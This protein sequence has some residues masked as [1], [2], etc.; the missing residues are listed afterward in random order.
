MLKTNDIKIIIKK[1]KPSYS[2]LRSHEKTVLLITETGRNDAVLQ[3]GP[4]HQASCSM[5][6]HVFLRCNTVVSGQE[7]YNKSLQGREPHALY[8]TNYFS[9]RFRIKAELQ[10]KGRFLS[11]SF[12]HREK[13]SERIYAQCTRHLASIWANRLMN[14]H[15]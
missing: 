3:R 2:D 4:V 11:E 7:K 15:N 9:K 8:Y 10:N 6:D 13:S 1:C 12:P 14:L 5:Y